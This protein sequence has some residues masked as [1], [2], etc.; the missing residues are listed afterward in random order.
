MVGGFGGQGALQA[1]HAGPSA[2][3]AYF[4]PALLVDAPAGL[5]AGA[6]ILNTEVGIS[7]DPRTPEAAVPDGLANGVYHADGS[8][9]SAFPIATDLLQNGKPAEGRTPALPARPRQRAGSGHQTN[10]YEAVGLVLKLFEDRLALGMYAMLPNVNFTQFNTFFANEKEQAFSNSLHPELY[11]DRLKAVSLAVSG[12][13][14]LTDTF[15]VGMGITMGLRAIAK[16]AAFVDDAGNLTDLDLNIDAVAKV[17]LIPQFGLSW[18][19]IKRLHLTGTLHA[20]QKLDIKAGFKFLIATGNEQGSGLGFTYDFMP[21]QAGLGAG[22]D[23]IQEKDLVV[24]ATASM[25]YGRWSQYINRQSYRPEGAY[26]WNDTISAAGGLRME[27]GSFGVALDG[28][29]KPTPVPLQTGRYNYVDNDR[30]GL[31]LAIHYGFEFM[32][33][34]MK[35]GLM[36]QGHRLIERHQTKLPVPTSADGVNRTPQL[37]TDE[38]PDDATSGGQPLAGREGLQTNNPGWPGFSSVGWVSSAGLYLS[39]FL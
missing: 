2:A 22:V 7:V 28:Q 9:L 4:N 17:E 27:K 38:V 16:A 3:S 6:L 15:S 33:Q 14:R 31:A 30:V 19:P 36:L 29:Y 34:N 23:L 26:E 10:T 39:V 21:W 11:G 25:L 32:K 24:T 12:G 8:R 18:R 1:R 35:L 5:T 20:P 37:V 13:V